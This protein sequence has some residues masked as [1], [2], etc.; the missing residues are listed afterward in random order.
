MSIR[1]HDIV[2]CG[3][4]LVGASLALA[5][6][7]LPLDICLLDPAPFAPAPRADDRT[8]TIA[9]GSKRAL[10]A[11]G[12]WSRLSRADFQPITEIEVSDRSGRFGLAHILA[13]EQGVDALGY[14]TGNAALLAALYGA[15]GTTA[16]TL[17]QGRF[18]GLVRDANQATITLADGHETERI[19][20]R[21]LVGAD[22]TNSAVRAACGIGVYGHDYGRCAIVSNCRVSRPR[23]HTAFER[24]T[25]NGPIA[26]LPIGDDRYT[27]VVSR[28]DGEQWQALDETDFLDRL[29]DVFGDRLGRLLAASPRLRFPLMRQQARE[30]VAPHVVLVGNAAHTLHPV[31]GQGFNLG[32]RDVAVLAE[33]LAQACRAHADY[34]DRAWLGDY[35][36]ARQADVANT[37]RF[38]DGLVR[39]FAPRQL[40]LAAARGLALNLIDALPGLKRALAVRT[41][42]LKAPL[43]R[44]F[45]ELKP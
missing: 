9:Q 37:T 30:W 18:G 24:F 41:M 39:L 2:I 28:P 15:L 1:R 43:P 32:L 29:A 21:L 12:V 42:G 6:A 16:V 45:R 44:L 17:R 27:F 33:R 20:C 25:A 10:T 11:L 26:A 4:G 34:G 3:G 40:P 7:P 22:G 14:V 23:P 19:A 8:F 36:R 38:T 5:L 13:E 35:A 31:A